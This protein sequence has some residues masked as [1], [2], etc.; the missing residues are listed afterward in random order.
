MRKRLKEL[1]ATIEDFEEFEKFISSYQDIVDTGKLA[2][3]YCEKLFNLTPVIPRNQYS[4]DALDAE[5]KRVEIKHRFYSTKTPPGMKINLENIDYVLYVDIDEETFLPTKIYKIN[6]ENIEYKTGKRV[7]FKKAFDK[8]EYEVLFKK[9]NSQANN[10]H[11]DSPLKLLT[12][13]GFIIF[14]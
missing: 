8:N 2:E 4:Y 7:S 13:R 1:I 10:Y 12:A 6:A 3:F 5:G 14:F 11:E 9:Y